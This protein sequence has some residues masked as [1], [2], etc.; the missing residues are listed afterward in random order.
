MH[1]CALRAQECTGAAV[2]QETAGLE[3]AG[4]ETTRLVMEG[5]EKWRIEKF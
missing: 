3:T 4:L 1:S 5:R 2:E